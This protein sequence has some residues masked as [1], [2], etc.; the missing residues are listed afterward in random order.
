MVG[1]GLDPSD[2]IVAGARAAGHKNGRDGDGHQPDGGGGVREGILQHVRATH[3]G[4]LGIAPRPC[5]SGVNEAG[6]GSD[7]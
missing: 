7:G 3:G 5:S 1:G 4:S 6:N 2:E